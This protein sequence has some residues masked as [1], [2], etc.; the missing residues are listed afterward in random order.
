MFKHTQE[1][2]QYR[3]YFKGLP[4]CPL[5]GK[6]AV[7]CSRHEDSSHNNKSPADALQDAQVFR[8][9]EHHRDGG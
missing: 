4:W 5:S 2:Q 9:Q 1:R 7:L 6:H 8:R 3:Q